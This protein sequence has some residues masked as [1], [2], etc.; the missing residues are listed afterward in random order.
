MNDQNIDANAELEVSEFSRADTTGVNRRRILKPVPLS[1]ALV[2][3][4]LGAAALF[5]VTAGAVKFD[6]TPSP[7]S[8]EITSGFFSYRLGE[9]FLMLPGDYTIRA[10]A[11]GYHEFETEVTVSSDPNQEFEFSMLKLPGI[12]NVASTPVSD[13]EVFVD[14][15][16]MGNTPL[17][18]DIEPG[19][20]DILFQ[21]DRYLPYQTEVEIEG[22][23]VEQTVAAELSPAWAI[24]TVSSEPPAADVM[25]DGTTLGQS[26][27]T[28]EVLQG[29]HT[30]G[31]KKQGFKLWQSNIEVS[32]GQELSLDLVSLI[33]SDGKLSIST[34]PI[35]ANIT[36]AER[37]RGQSPLSISLAPGNAYEILLSKAGFEPIRRS[38]NIEPDQDIALNLKMTP[39]MGV[40]RLQVQ[41][42]GAELF[43]NGKSIG[44]TSQR[45]NLTATRHKIEVIKPGFA[46]YTATITPQPGL[47]QQML[48]N[49]QTEEEARAAAIPTVITAMQDVTAN[50]IIPDKLAMGA[51]RREPGRRSNEIERQVQLTRAYY[52]G[53][54][55]ITNLAYKDFDPSHNSGMLGRSLLSDDERPVVNTSWERV[56]RFCN[57]LSLKN[58]L[59]AAYEQVGNIWRLV[60]PVNT[61]FRLP[62]EAEWAWAAR[63][64]KGDTPTR[65]PWGDNMPPPAGSGNFAD[66]SAA[67]MV[68]YHVVGYNDTYRGPAPVGSFS[69]NEF[70]IY[71][72]NGNVSEWVNDIYTASS[73]RELL[74]DPTGPETGDYYVIRGSNYTSGRFSEL[75]WTYRDYGKDPRPDVGFRIARY[76]E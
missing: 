34:N 58:G 25:L 47:A 55:E 13:A 43:L 20:H 37:Y 18:I 73:G 36:I 3:T 40:V 75:R 23:R 56:A 74:I 68:P 44:D 39:V 72:L 32:A 53:T 26:P 60:Q 61:G 6:I 42:E 29:E 51:S 11:A 1:I 76:V 33:K 19:L 24:V 71:D 63:Y 54:H 57:W 16:Y 27:S 7:D 69:A 41:P 5:I 12:L 9:R 14:Q 10:T 8:L 4:L 21:S 38:V 46:T 45:L 66:E 17:T 30:I 65:F 22:R 52:L 49:L 62:T 28:I 50:L 35:G 15:V 67:N 70:G 48:I 2:F 59:P 64:D 31:L